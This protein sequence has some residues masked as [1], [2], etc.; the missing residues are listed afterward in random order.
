MASY[1][2]FR[3]CVVGVGEEVIGRRAETPEVRG[4][5]NQYGDGYGGRGGGGMYLIRDNIPL[6]FFVICLCP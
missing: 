5:E 1:C 3:C 4:A 6:W 2:L